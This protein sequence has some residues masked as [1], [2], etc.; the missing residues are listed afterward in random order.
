MIRREVK[1][2]A[3]ELPGY[4]VFGGNIPFGALSA[5]I[6]NGLCSQSDAEEGRAELPT[7][8]TLRA[9][10]E[11]SEVDA[12]KKYV[13][14]ELSGVCAK[15][16]LFFNGKSCGV[17]S[18]PY[19]EYLFD[20]G[21]K[22]LPGDNIAEIR[23]S[24]PI[25]PKQCLDSH[26]ERST[27]Y[28]VA[29]RVADY[30][31]LNP[32]GLYV[33]D[34]AFIS[35]VSVRQEHYDGKVNLF[36]DA[37]AVGDKNDVR[38]VA[39]LS[40]PSGKIYFG[41]AYDEKI[42]INVSDP[43]LWWP[44]GYG[45]QPIYKLT[46]TLYHGADVADVYEK[47]IGLRT[48]ALEKGEGDVY[49]VLINGVKIFSRGAAYVK[50][51]AIYSGVTNAEIE[52]LIKSAVKANMNTLTVFDE[53]VP[54][55]DVFYELCDKYGILV[56]QSLT[57]PYIAP[58]AASVFAAGVTASVEDR[59]KRLSSHPSVALFFLSVVETGKDMMR[60]FKD[61]LEEFRTVSVRILSSVLNEYA[62][63]VPFLG[64]PYD[65]FK[66]DERYLYEK[67]EGYAYGTLYALPA[68]YTLKSYL[69]EEE[70]NLFSGVSEARTNVAE[71]IVMLENTVKHMKMPL[72]MGE[73][74]YASELA[75][76]IELSRS[77]K[78]ARFSDRS[79][80]ASLRQ[81]NDGR[82]TVSS[83]M[84][85]SLGKAKA[86]LKFIREANAPVTL[87]I[88]PCVDETVFRVINS[89][90]RGY[91]GKLMFAL[92]D[93][94]GKC[95][96]E[97]HIEVSLESGEK[98][99]VYT[100][101]FSR[102]IGDRRECFYIM[103]ELYDE[104]GMITSGG[105]HFVPLKHVKFVDPQIS[106]EISG[107]GKRFTAKLSSERYAYAVKIDFEDLNVNF[108]SN[109][110]NLYGKTPVLVDFETA[111]VLTVAELEKS[112]RIYTPYSIGR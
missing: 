82:R 19:R 39:S 101:D 76:A 40:A 36:V 45:A 109:F 44:R 27:A 106:A 91:S 22:A 1:T 26:G 11:L 43:E 37:T 66:D 63:S 6:K 83:A 12:K 78:N 79:S 72:G 38:I 47:R 4:E 42:K 51:S 69:P 25:A 81:L 111:E 62:S 8:C 97:K 93:T 21:D 5:M 90:R 49:S 104:K 107:M 92:Y 64:N 100:A 87:D 70:Y 41:G 73:L 96:E 98:S 60:L 80:G 77:V 55:P 28:D 10:I 30:A 2:L 17:I 89:G 68:E 86:P 94:N 24:E 95:Y 105:E 110:V 112:L 75:A 85:D 108:G 84:I 46:V 20:V 31:V 58:P 57:L 54:T 74:V 29:E 18:G 32:I 15:G 48:V 16:E 34:S 99:V 59:V 53:N 14:L 23:C 67:D 102:H 61:S 7:S 50:E 13:Y 3:V 52:A 65:L 88:D 56:W 103:Y 33:S 9:T 71:C 35:G